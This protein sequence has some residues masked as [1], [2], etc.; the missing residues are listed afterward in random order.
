RT[1]SAVPAALGAVEKPDPTRTTKSPSRRRFLPRVPGVKA[2][3]APSDPG[4]AVRLEH[5]WNPIGALAGPRADGRAPAGRTVHFRVRV[6][7]GARMEFGILGPLE[8]VSE[9]ESIALGGPK[10]R[11]VLA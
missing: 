6:P 10:Q 7:Y 2:M 4:V 11:A 5:D 3:T 9:G 8:V 1:D